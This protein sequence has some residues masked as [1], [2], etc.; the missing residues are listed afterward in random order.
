MSTMLP[1]DPAPLAD[2]P[3]VGRCRRYL[4]DRDW[5]EQAKPLGEAGPSGR[6][7]P[8]APDALWDGPERRR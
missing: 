3:F 5:Q 6:A 4:F 7:A 2:R 8:G 1:I